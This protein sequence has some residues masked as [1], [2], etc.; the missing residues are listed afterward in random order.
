MLT[1]EE[2]FACCHPLP[3]SPENVTTAKAAPDPDHKVPTCVPVFWEPLKKRIPL[4]KP[5]VSEENFRPR[6]TDFE[7]LAAW[8]CGTAAELQ[9]EVWANAGKLTNAV[10][11]M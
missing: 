2:K 4:T 3:V 8:T 9:N 7:S 1:G 10:R 5:A 6:L 11:S